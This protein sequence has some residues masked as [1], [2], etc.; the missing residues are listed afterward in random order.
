MPKNYLRENSWSSFLTYLAK[1]I[2]NQN[3]EAKSTTKTLCCNPF[4][5][6]KWRFGTLSLCVSLGKYISCQTLSFKAKRGY[7]SGHFVLNKRNNS[8]SGL[9]SFLCS[10]VIKYT[11][12]KITIKV[13]CAFQNFHNSLGAWTI[14]PRAPC[15]QLKHDP[16]YLGDKIDSF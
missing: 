13:C 12:D 14:I 6:S 1:T 10:E 7:H 9:N 5:A 11:L 3:F 16:I 2:L 8:N 4:Q 15:T